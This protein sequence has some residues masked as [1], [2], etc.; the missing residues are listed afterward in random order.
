MNLALIVLNIIILKER[1]RNLRTGYEQSFSNWLDT[2][3]V[4]Q[5]VKYEGWGKKC[6]RKWLNVEFK[7]PKANG[8]FRINALRKE[9][10]F[11]V[12]E[13]EGMNYSKGTFFLWDNMTTKFLRIA[14]VQLGLDNLKRLSVCH[15][16]NCTNALQIIWPLRPILRQERVNGF[17]FWPKLVRSSF[18]CTCCFPTYCCSPGPQNGQGNWNDT[19]CD[20][21]SGEIVGPG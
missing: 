19:G 15:Q 16:T 18:Y 17:Y 12:T 9:F 13:I 1:S 11:V 2:M 8:S 3:T 21:D 4:Q 6:T 5:K 20:E 7:S 14:N 10:K